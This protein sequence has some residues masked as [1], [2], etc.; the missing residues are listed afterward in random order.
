MTLNELRLEIAGI[1]AEAKKKKDKADD[2]KKQGRSVEAFGLYDEAFDFSAPLGAYNLYKQQ[3][4]VNWGP[5]TSAG[6]DVDTNFSHPNAGPRLKESEMALRA[7][8]RE[9]IENGLVPQH[10]AWAPLLSRKTPQTVWESAD[11]MFEA[12]YDRAKKSK[13]D[14]EEP[15]KAKKDTDY[16]PVKKH[17]FEKKKKRK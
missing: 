8:V 5:Y 12:W 13:K 15:K 11:R 2:L 4:A 10:S 1:L 6:T 7:V 3:G 17:G 9:V 14:E 16:G